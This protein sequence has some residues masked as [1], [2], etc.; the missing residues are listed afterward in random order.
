MIK[1]DQRDAVV[2]L[3]LDRPEKRN[4]LHP[5][6]IR[7]L[8]SDLEKVESDGS[9]KV[10]VIA[11]AG[12]TFCAGLDLTHLLRLDT[13]AKIQYLRTFFSLFRQIYTLPQPVIA[14]ING[15]AIA[16]GFDLA[17]ACDLRLCSPEATFAQTEILLG[18][19]QLLYPLYKVV[20]LGR[21]KELA[22]TG[23]S[24]S[25]EEAFRMG[26][27]NRVCPTDTLSSET[28]RLA[29]LLASRPTEAL[30]ATKRLSRE[31]IEMTT[32]M[33]IERMFDRISER[34][35]S[36]EHQHHSALYLSELKRQQ[37]THK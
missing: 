5:D 15:A 8:S 9:T 10:V 35:Q 28:M 24:I 18:L 27:V 17:L 33:A 4:S 30:F 31:V 13:N 25:A 32:D 23:Q 19:T 26:L 1:T 14:C 2:L 3:T 6:M 29:Q 21:A 20:G 12:T 34:L 7:D 16:G 37:R 22:M 11:G 36:E